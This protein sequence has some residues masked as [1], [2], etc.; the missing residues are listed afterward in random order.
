MLLLQGALWLLLL[1]LLKV[2]MIGL[3][4]MRVVVVVIVVDGV[5][6]MSRILSGVKWMLLLHQFAFDSFSHVGA[7]F[8]AAG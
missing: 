2:V 1:W 8:R 6:E 5:G 7:S 4:L 3:L